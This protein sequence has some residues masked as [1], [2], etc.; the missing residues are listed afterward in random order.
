MSAAC[1]PIDQ[2]VDQAWRA[3]LGEG[4]V[5]ADGSDPAISECANGDGR[6]WTTKLSVGRHLVFT[7]LLPGVRTREDER[8]PV[9]IDGHGRGVVE[10]QC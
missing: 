8:R 3:P 4:G 2:V 6:K 7:S 1:Q 10:L 5:V 9:L